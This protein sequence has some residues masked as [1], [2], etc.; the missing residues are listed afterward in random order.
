MTTLSNPTCFFQ[1]FYVLAKIAVQNSLS[2]GVESHIHRPDRRICSLD[3]PVLSSWVERRPRQLLFQVFFCGSRVMEP[4][5]LN[6]NDLIAVHDAYIGY[7]SVKNWLAD[8][9]KRL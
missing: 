1:H 6:K 4:Q 5:E 9:E 7:N 3:L 8:I 2:A